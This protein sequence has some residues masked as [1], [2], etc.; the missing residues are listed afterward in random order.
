MSNQFEDQYSADNFWGKVKRYT[1]VMGKGVLGPAL[2]LYYAGIDPDTPANAKAVIFGAL[3]Y[4][5]SPIDAI[6]D[7]TPVVG[8]SDD[9]GVLVAA[10]AFVGAHIKQEHTDKAD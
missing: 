6:P 1:K 3:G 8:Y 9:L 7:V 10:V 2:Q 4:L 5:I